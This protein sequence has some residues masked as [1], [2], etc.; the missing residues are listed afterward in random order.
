MIMIYAKVEAGML[1]NI[2][3][4]TAQKFRIIYSAIPFSE[5]KK[6][7]NSVKTIDYQKSNH[8]KLNKDDLKLES[9]IRRTCRI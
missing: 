9:I 6:I 1:K 4:A 5:M 3:A 8:M 7:I 2:D